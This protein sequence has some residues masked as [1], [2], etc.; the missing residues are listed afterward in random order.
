MHVGHGRID[1][2]WYVTKWPTIRGEN[3]PQGIP[4]RCVEAS[5]GTRC[6]QI[7]LWNFGKPGRT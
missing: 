6:I 7:R 3:P 1:F 2:A 5:I 4:Y